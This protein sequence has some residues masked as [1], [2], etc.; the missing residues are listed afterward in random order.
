MKKEKKT[1]I[2]SEVNESDGFLIIENDRIIDCSTRMLE[3]F[4]CSSESEIIGHRFYELSPELQHNGMYSHEHYREMVEEVHLSGKCRF[5]CSF[6][7]HSRGEVTAEV[8]F[9]A[10]YIEGK[11]VIVAII[12]VLPG[13]E[14]VMEHISD[15]EDID[16]SIFNNRHTPM[17]IIKGESGEIRDANIAACNYYGYSRDM[18]LK[19]KI[20]EINTLSQQEVFEEMSRASKEDRKFF[21][22]KHRLAGGE[23]KEVEVY[24]GPVTIKGESLLFSIIHDVED[25]RAMERKIML[26]ESYFESLYENSPEAIVMLDNEFRV[27]SVNSSFERIFQYR[28]DEIRNQ[29][30]TKVLCEEEFYDESSYFKD[31]IKRGEF[32]REETLRRRKDGKLVDV[33]FLGYPIISNGEQVGVYGIYS[34]LSIVKETESK[35]RLFSEIFKNNTVG[36]VV[37]DIDGNIQWINDAFTEVTGYYSAE[38]VGR[39][40]SILKSGM[41]DNE[42][43]SNMWNTILST[44]KWQGEVFNKRKDGELYQEWLIIIAIRDDRGNIEH[45]VGMMNDITDARQKENRI[46]FLTNKDSLTDLYNREYFVN[47]LNYEISRR[48]KGMDTEKELAIIFLDLDD[49]KEINDNLGHLAG[50][51][52]LKEFASRLKGSVR[53]YDIAAR[54]GG[55]EFIV[56]ILYVREYL[57]II[58]IANRIIDETSKPFL[59]DNLELHITASLGIS[60]YPDDGADSTTLIRNADIAMYR[61]K[62]GKNKKITIFESSLDEELKEYF[63]IKNNLRNAVTNNELFL[64]YQPIFDVTKG[65]IIGTEALVRWN[66]NNS[67]LIPPLKFIPVAEKNG[68]MQS[69]G[70]WVLR[71]ACRQNRQW[72]ES[73]YGPIFISVNVS[74]VQ[75]EQAKFCEIVKNALQESQLKPEYLQLEITETI[76]TKNY[77]KIVETIKAINGLGVKVAIDDFGTGYSSLGQLSRLE[78]NKLKIDRSFINEINEN[79]NKNK[80]V[81]AIIS[82]AESLSLEL[83]AEGVETEAQLDFL[84]R[85]ECN[86][87]QGYLYSKPVLP[88]ELEQLLM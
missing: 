44:G 17:L 74:I 43:Y 34:D 8:L 70:E 52:V 48:N 84:V 19:M 31:S 22:F 32:V 26:Q 3:I 11:S 67:E 6:Q 80:I 46:E 37:T 59:I 81:R 72:Q 69:I 53:E 24:S 64:E 13:S 62:E 20:T 78:I 57:E 76:F 35:K 61:S 5:E 36:V 2:L 66:F 39:K 12:R 15:T 27:I 18:L 82:L 50:D 68:F 14:G 25:K 65:K 49:F 58:H 30:I 73:G 85:N 29:N 87:V 41:H 77:D 56:L 55:D 51:S 60:R 38:V 1:N 42:Y 33:S 88:N 47:K 23:I 7:T 21:R 75:L 45:F 83:I 79:E 63:K 54:F 71:T 86:M 9:T 40:P 28:I 10:Q 16:C 4:G